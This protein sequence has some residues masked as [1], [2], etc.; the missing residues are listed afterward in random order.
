MSTLN[1]IRNFV[2]ID[3]RLA[4]SGMPQFIQDNR[5][6]DLARRKH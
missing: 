2:R 1:H 4:T 6:T 3:D 5:T